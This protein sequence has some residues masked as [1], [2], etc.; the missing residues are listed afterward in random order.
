M[1]G[2]FIL[3]HFINDNIEIF[4]CPLA[5]KIKALYCDNTIALNKN[6]ST[7]AE[8]TCILAEELGHHYTSCGDILDQSK[9]ENIKAEK[10]ARR[11]AAEKLIR[12]HD[13]IDAF[14]AGVSNRAELAE[15]LDVTEKFIEMAL[16][17]FINIHGLFLTIDNYTICFD[18]L[19]V[20][21]NFD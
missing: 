10:R 15:F 21:K 18:P 6:L 16:E 8:E 17:H 7:T 12:P 19:L 3:K 1:S 13:F 2:F 5:G 9:T 20:I 4:H 14:N 11:W